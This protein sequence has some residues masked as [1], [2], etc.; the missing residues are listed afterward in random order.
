MLIADIS[1]PNNIVVSDY[2]SMFPNTAFPPSGPDAAFM[3]AHQLAPVNMFLPY[4]QSTQM[5]QPCA[6]YLLNG[7]VYTVAAVALTTDQI[8]TN[9]TTLKNQAINNVNISAGAARENFITEVSG[10]D[11]TYIQKAAE[12]AAYVTNPSGTYP[13]LTREAFYT[14]MT[15]AQVAALINSTADTWNNQLNPEIE[16]VR[17]GANVAITAATTSALVNNLA[18]WAEGAFKN[19]VAGTAVDAMPTS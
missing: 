10:Q 19:I 14:N 11:A 15:V 18:I 4:N 1:N 8:A 16:G 9:L 3:T 17:R 12:A 6:P 13:Y 2:K 5:L 7:Q